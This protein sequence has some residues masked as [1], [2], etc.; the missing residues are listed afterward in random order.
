MFEQCCAMV[1]DCVDLN[2]EGSMKDCEWSTDQF[3]V[4]L[5]KYSEQVEV[6]KSSKV[7]HVAKMSVYI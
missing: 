7:L 5:S 2:I 6:S 3:R 4:V 1:K